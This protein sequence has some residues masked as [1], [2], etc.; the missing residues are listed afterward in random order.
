[1]RPDGSILSAPGYDPAT[2][3]YHAVNDDLILSPEVNRPTKQD[4][5]RALQLLCGLLIE[6][7]FVNDAS[8][9]VALSALISP[10][11]R[12]A[13]QVVPLHA[14]RA[15]TAGSGKSFLVDV[16]SAIAT[17]NICP[18]AA[19]GHDDA[20]TEKRLA[21][22]MLAGFPIVNL[23]NVNG[24][25][26]GDLLCQAIER[27]IVRVRRLGGSDITEIENRV[28]LFATGNGLRVR[29]DMVRRTL[30][31]DLDADMER[32][33]LRTFSANPVETVLQN[34]GK[35]VSAC[36]VIVRA[37]ALAGR[38]GA[39]PAIASFEGWSNN[40]RSALVWLGCEDAAKSIEQAREDD[41][42]LES[43]A[44]V[45]AGWR[46]A[47]GSN[48]VTC[49]EVVQTAFMRDAA[50]AGELKFPALHDA[51]VRVAGGPRGLIDAVRLGNWLAARKGRIV[52]GR[53]F[54]RAAVNQG[55]AR[56]RIS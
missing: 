28:S 22:L 46:E 31:C 53:R 16:A 5:A 52:A 7:P 55:T 24:E 1:M 12:G 42:E 2:R 21:G 40:V 30:I 50:A 56:W 6:F 41:P 34:R 26:G 4:A 17:G 33:E 37:Y 27:P 54:E 38:P 45:M 20:E 43:I 25:L 39:L 44:A 11:V 32:P 29:G 8:L 13:M 47:F 51:L 19:A 23:D 10:V 49:R 14:F 48:S 15:T 18:V 3:L 9:A 35:Y 36:L